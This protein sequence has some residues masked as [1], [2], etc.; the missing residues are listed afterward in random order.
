[1]YLGLR[2]LLPAILL[3][4]PLLQQKKRSNMSQNG[5]GGD[6][7]DDDDDDGDDDDVDKHDDDIFY[8]K[9]RFLGLPAP[10]QACAA[11]LNALWAPS[12]A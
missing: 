5:Y 11:F 2:R 3:K 10:R 1:M 6:D 12:E 8:L 7:D 4:L 9:S